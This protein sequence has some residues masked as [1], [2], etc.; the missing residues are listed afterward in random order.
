M[1]TTFSFVYLSYIE[2]YTSPIEDEILKNGIM[3]IHSYSLFTTSVHLGAAIGSLIAG[4][5]SELL[6]IKTSLI[7]FSQLG[8]L[9]AIFLVL[10]H[11]VGSMVVGRILIGLYTSICQSC[12]P[13]YNAEVSTGSMRI[14]F[15]AILGL[16]IRFGILL[17]FFL[18]IWIGYRWLAVIYILM[19][20]F[21]NLNLVFIPESPKWLRDR[22]WNKKADQACEYFYN[23]SQEGLLRSETASNSKN[24]VS[25][26]KIKFSKRI[27]D[28]L[29]WPVIRPLLVCSSVQLFK[30]LSCHEY[31]VVYSAHTLDTAVSINPRVAAFFYPISLVIGSTL[32]LW[33]IH[34][35]HWKRLLLVTTLVQILANGL[36]SLTLYLSIQIFHCTNNTQDII[37]CQIL[38]FTPIVLIGI[39]GFSFSIGCGSISW[40][41]YGQILH[42][43]YTSVSAGIVNSVLY[44]AAL[45][46]QIIGPVVVEYFGVQTLF[47]IYAIKCIIAIIIQFFY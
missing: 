4:P 41:L 11:D 5:V 2:V 34:K 44:I 18:G 33:I 3:K 26:Q 9:G 31:L 6:G 35:V 38:Q 47:L 46:D 43:K 25:T 40:W 36:L 45:T 10:A 16:A 14:I 7:V 29:I 15:G 22:G 8:T 20:V 24:E 32:F 21:T 37:L 12:V 19:V 1:T 17:S 27:T 30:S 39:Y 42:S 23:S 13:V 28:Y